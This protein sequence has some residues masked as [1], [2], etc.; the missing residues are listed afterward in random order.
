VT[1]HTIRKARERGEQKS[2]GG[3]E[4]VV[5]DK[6]ADERGVQTRLQTKE[7]CRRKRLLR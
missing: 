4:S 2:H 5:G 6:I 7:G 1:Q 3:E